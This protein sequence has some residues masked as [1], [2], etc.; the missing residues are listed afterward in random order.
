[1]TDADRQARTDVVAPAEHLRFDEA[2]L[3][4]YLESRLEG[5]AGPLEVL[6]FEGGQSNPTYLLK[7]PERRYVLRRK[8]PGKLLPSAHA[9]DRE[10]R[11]MAAL[12][13]VGFPVPQTR[14]YCED[15]GV[16]GTPFFV[17]DFV[18]GRI[19]W[20]G[21]LPN[22][23]PSAR[24]AIYDSANA[25]MAALHRVDYAAIGLEDYGRPDNYMPRQIARWTKQY[26]ASE[27]DK[28]D[29]MEKLIEWLPRHA[30]AQ[31]AASIVHG[32]YRLDNLIFH[33]ERDEVIAVLDWEL[34][35]IG[36]PL[37]DFTYF[38]MQ[39]RMP[40]SFRGGLADL[41]DPGYGV[42]PAESFTAL[43]A[44]R[45]G[46]ALSTDDLNSY[47]AYNIF[48]IIAI[49]QGVVARGL[50][51][52]AASRRALDYRDALKPLAERA[53]AIAHGE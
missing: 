31:S 49:L 23:S 8:P 12:K 32:D 1:M 11:I 14:L 35:T 21:R 20:D 2:H 3:H 6:Q 29:A 38:L 13:S 45:S 51:G 42:P 10:H 46:H 36:D 47:L 43:Y 28:I 48:R 44:E 19:F 24:A 15:E 27:I 52:N 39:W 22:E 4:A 34:S 53:W 33:P 40:G 25:T 17:M 26:R 30:P 16:V 18:D 50:A 7:T 9:V 41:D 5:Y 37:A